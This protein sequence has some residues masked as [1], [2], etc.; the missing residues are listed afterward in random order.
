M[1]TAF[2][3]IAGVKTPVN[4]LPPAIAQLVQAKL[5][6]EKPEPVDPTLWPDPWDGEDVLYLSARRE[7]FHRCALCSGKRFVPLHVCV[8]HS[9][10]CKHALEF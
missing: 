8:S 6:D 2:V 9:P 5:G 10:T 1:A 4:E 3:K 7:W